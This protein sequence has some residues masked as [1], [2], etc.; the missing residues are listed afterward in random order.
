MPGFSHKC[1]CTRSLAALVGFALAAPFHAL[2]T[3]AQNIIVPVSGDHRLV[4]LDPSNTICARRG[5]QVEVHDAD[6]GVRQISN[7]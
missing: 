5:E 4:P 3:S 1:S 7:V 6:N 2:E